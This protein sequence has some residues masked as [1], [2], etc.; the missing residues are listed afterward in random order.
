M[1]KCS[2]CTQ[3]FTDPNNIGHSEHTCQA[4]GAL[5]Q[6]HIRG[7]VGGGGR[8]PVMMKADPQPCLPSCKHSQPDALVPKIVAG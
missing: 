3:E 4:C 8:G 2:N 1:L 6:W 7:S 5:L